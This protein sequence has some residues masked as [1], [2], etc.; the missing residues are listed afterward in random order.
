[1]SKKSVIEL[2]RKDGLYLKDTATKGRGV[3][4]LYD[5]KAGEELEITPALILDE[6]DNDKA[7]DT[8]LNNYVFTTGKISAGMR[9]S[10]GIK[11]LADT[12]CVIM[13]V[14][15]FCN[16][17]DDVPNAEIAWQ[18]DNGSL[19]Y[20]LQATRDIPKGTEICTS[21]GDTWFEER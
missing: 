7:E 16:H 14:G 10:L 5:I 20:T 17:A 1:M 12:S 9:K 13:G 6:H 2:M 3:F 19:Y 15:S 21:Y 4:C 18:E 8:L 11:K